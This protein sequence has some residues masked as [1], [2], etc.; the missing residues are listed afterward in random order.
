MNKRMDASS[1][2]LNTFI[3]Q[4]DLGEGFGMED[5]KVKIVQIW[6]DDKMR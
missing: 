3:H 4:F 1:E 6:K 5:F 2:A